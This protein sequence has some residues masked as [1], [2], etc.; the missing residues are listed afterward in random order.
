MPKPRSRQAPAEGQFTEGAV[1]RARVRSRQ[2][3]VVAAAL[4][5]GVTMAGITTYELVSGQS[6]GGDSTSTT[7]GDALKGSGSGTGSGSKSERG[8]TPSAGPSESPGPSGV[9]GTGSAQDDSGATTPTP[10][11]SATATTPAPDAS[12]RSQSADPDQAGPAG[13]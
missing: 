5:F 7:V 11:P 9:S 4:V 2:R 1:H 10:T 6:F 13:R 12:S 3:P 8:G